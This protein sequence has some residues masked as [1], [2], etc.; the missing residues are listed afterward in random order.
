MDIL[1]TPQFYSRIGNQA[2]TLPEYWQLIQ[3]K[4][5]YVHLTSLEYFSVS[6]SGQEQQ[7]ILDVVM[8]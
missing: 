1:I 4:C 3:Q 7:I 8:S 5:T 2:S 6:L